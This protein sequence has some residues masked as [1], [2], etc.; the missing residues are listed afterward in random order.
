MA[1]LI[2]LSGVLLLAGVEAAQLTGTAGLQKA[3]DVR[4]N[5]FCL[6]RLH[7]VWKEAEQ[8][9]ASVVVTCFALCE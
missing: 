2:L 3:Q 1:T 6:L 7:S 5:P 9:Y 8:R 4:K